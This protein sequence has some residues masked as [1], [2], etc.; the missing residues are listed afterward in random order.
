MRAP[1]ALILA[2][3][4]QSASPATKPKNPVVQNSEAPNKT[5]DSKQPS[6]LVPFNTPVSTPVSHPTADN[7]KD[8]H[9]G[10]SDKWAYR[11]KVVSQPFDWLYL[12]YVVVTAIAA[13]VAWRALLGINRQAKLMTDQLIEMEKSRGQ[14]DKLIKS[15]GEQVAEMQ[16]AGL[17]TADL[18]IAAK[19]SAIAALSSAK[20]LTNSERA[21][22]VIRF[23][24]DER[25]HATVVNEGR[26]PAEVVWGDAKFSFCS[27]EEVDTIDVVLHTPNGEFPH[28][29]VLVPGEEWN[30]FYTFNMEEIFSGEQLASV[31]ANTHRLV[32]FGVIRYRD[33]LNE[34]DPT[35]HETRYCYWFD[36]KTRGLSMGGPQGANKHT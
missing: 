27:N 24:V 14:T 11:V 8:E 20:A 23:K 33:T 26:T 21:W 13:Y 10:E 17:Q 32:L 3:S 22:L 16:R 31:E 35:V 9:Q 15:A 2:L 19:E 1:I 4:L 12:V 18:I 28:R 5:S 29:K 36:P 25:F 7:K 34:S 6:P 30:F